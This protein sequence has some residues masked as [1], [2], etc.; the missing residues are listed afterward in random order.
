MHDKTQNF[1]EIQADFQLYYN[2]IV[3]SDGKI[4][5][6]TGIKQFKRWEY[7]WE[8]RVD[9]N[10]NFP[11]AGHML[12]EMERYSRDNESYRSYTSGTGT[13]ESLGPSL[14]PGNGTGQL[15]G[16]GRLNCIAFHPDDANTIY[17]GAPSGG[18]WTSTDNGSSWTQ[19]ISGLTRLGVSS[20]VVHPTIPSTIYIGTGDRDGGDV[21]G[22]GVWRSTDSGDTWSA[23]H[24]GMPNTTVGEIIMDP[25]DSS[26]M[27][28][29]CHNGYIYRTTDGGANWSASNFLGVIAMDLAMHPTNSDT[30]YAGSLWGEFWRSLDGGATF[31]EITSGLGT[32]GNRIAIAVS[33]DEPDYVYALVGG[34]SGLVGIYRSTNSGTS[35]STRTTTP[36]ILGYEIDGSGTASQSSYDLVIAA[37]PTDADI[38]YTGGVNLWKSVNGGSTMSCVSYW[39]G[40][41]SG[42]DGVHADQHALEFSPHSGYLYNGNDGGMYVTSDEGSNWTDIS[43]GLNIAQ[44]Y[45]IGV[46]QQ[47]QDKVINGYQDNGTAIYANETFTTEIGGDGM[48]CII[49]PT[50]DTYMYGALYYGDIRRSSN[51]GS[52]F[53]SIS[54]A[55]GE[56]GSWVTP[57]KLDP[58]DEERLYAGYDDVWRTDNVKAGTPSWS[59]I[60]SFSGSNNIRDVA[61][62]PSNS[63]VMYVSRYGDEFYRSDNAT[64]ASPT[65]TDLSGAL[66]GSSSPKDIEIDPT[67][68]SHLYIA[69][70]NDIYESTNSGASW[71]NVSGTLP[72]ISLNTIVID[73]NGPTEGMYVGMDVGVYYDDNV[74]SDWTAYNS[75]LPAIEIREL[76]IHNGATNCKGTLYAST[77]GQGLWKSDLKDPGGYAPEAC[78]EA[79]SVTLCASNMVTITDLSS[80]TPTSWLWVIT[81]GT[82]SYVGG[83]SSSSQNPQVQFASAGTYTVK[84]TA[85]NAT[86]SDVETKNNYITV[87]TGASASTFDDDLESYSN[88]GTSNDCGNT[89]CTLTGGKWSNLTNGSDDDID[90]RVDDNGTG[91]SGTGPSVDD[92][93][94]TSSGNYIYTEASGC[95]AQTAILQS[96]C[97]EMDS[98]YVFSFAYHMY[99]AYMGVLHVDVFSEGAWSNDVIPAISGDQ[100]NAWFTQEVDLSDYLDE[101]VKLRF[102]GVT[103]SSYTSDISLDDFKFTSKPY[104]TGTTST[105]WNTDNNWNKGSVPTS[106]DEIYITSDPSNQP[107]VTLPA[108]T[109]AE[110]SNLNILSGAT[111]TVDAGK[112]LTVSGDTDNEGTIL[113]KADATGIG[114]FIDN[115][116]I[117]GAGT[118]QMEQYLT[119]SG[120]ATP[121]GLFYYVCS[122]MASATSNVYDAA[123]TDRLWSANEVTQSYGEITDNI[124][125]LS[126]AQGYIARMGAT[127]TQT[128]EGGSFNTGSVSA[129]GLTRT[130]IS[131]TN[132]GYNL[133]GNPY[134]STINWETSARTNLETTMWYRTHSGVNMLYDTYNAS[135]HVGTNNNGGGAV[136]RYIPPGQAFWVRV[137]ADGSTGQLDFDN[138]DRSHG[139]ATGIYRMAAE[140]GNIR[141]ALSNGTLSDEQIIL[142]NPDAS[143]NYDNYDS[144]KFWSNNVPQLYSNLAEDTLT[145]NGLYSPFTT[146]IVPLGM[147]IPTQGNYTLN[148][149][150]ITFTETAV[151]LEDA[152]LG[153]FQNLNVEPV[154]PFVSN[155]GNIEDRFVLHFAEVLQVDEVENRIS[156]HSNDNLIHVNLSAPSNGTITVLDM[157]GRTVHTQTINA[158]L[159]II[160]L[161]TTE[162]LYL[163][164]VET[165]DQTINR[166][167]FIQ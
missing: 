1:Y 39:V 26:I 73:P 108:G 95:Y 10:G 98:A 122:P 29:A 146:P 88:C 53:S 24:S 23:Y 33:A 18:F 30:I 76:E 12:N 52:S 54:S 49:D 161:Q 63:S 32:T 153:I 37:D 25:D 110:C 56:G 140:E 93:P 163:V 75:G 47:T 141:I 82:H 43:D 96:D 3:G 40:V 155:A 129:S 137:D 71:T 51:G 42:I 118:F 41:N 45:K 8:D 5:K 165:A 130:G 21:S 28:A 60:S 167:V 139:T 135:S 115:G 74:L 65:W 142:F 101:T 50:D 14:T 78:F 134:P 125:A 19:S 72:N 149:I 4:P 6:G 102:R 80:Y 148:A 121:S 128:F 64:V 104:W 106:S 114:S 86:G 160:Q 145:I 7:Y 58:N 66:P 34:S 15:N 131:E 119:G 103:G 2:S 166:K 69:F 144:Q 143:D 120:V 105:D 164:K 83:T 31:S 70:L 81:P 99:G 117:S 127:G 46:S 112:A 154:Y 138:A 61:I 77:Y 55:T 79:S 85:T 111:L 67:D 136:T 132:R 16:S 156:I 109:P 124:T 91:S 13:W 133:V 92:N 158:Q 27:Y 152:Y 62:A 116:T 20:I 57:Y 38:I 59:K 97:M 90:W 36:N 126:I 68:A 147:K 150:A 113:V 94:G 123:G 162:G 48:E 157:T 159:S 44:V 35:F 151:H 87:S 11:A 107:H 84:L 9:E 17:A 89:T 22:Y 100:T